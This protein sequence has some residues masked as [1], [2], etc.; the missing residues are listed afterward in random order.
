MDD[1]DSPNEDFKGKMSAK[2]LERYRVN[3]RLGKF[4]YKNCSSYKILKEIF[5]PKR[6]KSE[7]LSVATCLCLEIPNL[8]IDREAKRRKCVLIKW[9]HDNFAV[10]RPH[11]KNYYF[12]DEHHKEFKDIGDNVSEDEE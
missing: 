7:L 5:G 11:L 3:K 10:I 1:G 9:F 12:A 4:N 6:S 8:K 2:E